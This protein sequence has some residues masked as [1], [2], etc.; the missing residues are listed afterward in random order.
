MKRQGRTSKYS[1]ELLEKVVSEY[2]NT[3]KGAKELEVE[4]GVPEYTI[5][6]HT[7]KGRKKRNE[8]N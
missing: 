5:R 8:K 4:Y 7:K 2:L 1:K 6:Y 3:N